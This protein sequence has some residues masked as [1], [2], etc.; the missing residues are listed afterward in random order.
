M[1]AMAET[2]VCRACGHGTERFLAFGDLPLANA[3]VPIGTA[4]EDRFP[5]TMTFCRGCGL[6]QL[7]ETIDPARLFRH[8]V[9][10]SSNSP[11]FL[12]HA[13]TL[14]HRLIK[15]RSLGRDSRVI[16]IASNDG[17][18]LQYYKNAGI[19][20]LGVE[21]ARNIAEVARQRG[22]ET[23]G[24]FFSPELA[25]TLRADNRLAD[26]IHA[27]NVLAHVPDLR[28]F[29]AGLAAILRP[30]GIVVIE[31][32]Y[33]RDLV[34]KLE[35]DTVY[36]E[37]LCYFSLTPLIPL[38]ARSGLEIFRVER[39]PV[40]GGSLRLFARATG[41][42]PPEPSVAQMLAD[43]RH[44]GA[45]DTT[46]Y[47]RFADAVR[48]YRPTLRAF[49]ANLRA[50]GKSIAAYGASAKGATLLNYCGVD[51][52]LIDFVVDRSTLKQGLAMPG[53]QLPILA[54][55]ELLHRQPDFVLLLA[56]NFAD[57]VMEQQAEYRRHGGR[58][59]VPVPE[60]KIL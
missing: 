24:E 15:E 14:T 30:K 49:L 5:L 43:E 17:Y 33:V 2:T 23:I 3:L 48:S 28:G 46:V 45:A 7:A 21:P 53:V 27:N 25:A 51:R 50:A 20:V 38:F 40:H 26:V 19:S 57:E 36:H 55:D 37:H 11:A 44:W 1:A 18:L 8:Y 52:T 35:F 32:P 34:E 31:A 41:G 54:P 39:I 4:V 59:I 12:R 29:V 22:I 47:R 58:F 9:Y 42:G 13:Q 56:W 16:E 10:L 6:V 60:P